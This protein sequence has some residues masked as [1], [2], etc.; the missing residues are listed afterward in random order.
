MRALAANEVSIPV[1]TDLR[2]AD[3]EAGGEGAPLVPVFHRAL[4]ENAGLHRPIVLVNIT[5][6]GKGADDLIAFD[7]GPGNALTDDFVQRHGAARMDADGAFAAR[8]TVDED[9]LARWLDNPYFSR[10]AL[11]SLDRDAFSCEGL[12]EMS[13]E[14]GC[15]TLTAFTA[16]TI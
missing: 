1:V 15:A 10:R 4:V 16:E 9:A 8:G 7:T 14:G 13:L 6:I 11:K 2:V 3:V 12:E 5:W